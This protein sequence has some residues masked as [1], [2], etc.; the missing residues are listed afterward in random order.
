MKQEGKPR[1]GVAVFTAL[2]GC[3]A[4]VDNYAFTILL[5]IPYVFVLQLISLLYHDI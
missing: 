4:V 1:M 3:L 2:P 5:L